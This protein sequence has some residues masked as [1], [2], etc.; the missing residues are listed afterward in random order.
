[1]KAKYGVLVAALLTATAMSAPAFAQNSIAGSV[2]NSASL[3]NSTGIGLGGQGGTA[4]SFSGSNSRS[5]SVSNGTGYGGNGSGTGNATITF[6]DP[7]VPATTTQNIGG[8]ERIVTTG[9]AIAPSLYSN[10]VCA[11]SASAAGGFLG[12][13][14]ALGFDRVDHGCDVRANA[15][16]LGHFAEINRVTAT[17]S[18]DPQ[19][20]YRAEQAAVAYAQWA[21]NYICMANPDLAKAAPPGAG[22]CNQVATQ[23]GMEV[24]PAPV[25]TAYVPPVAPAATVVVPPPR[26]MPQAVAYHQPGT[27]GEHQG[28]PTSYHTGPISGYN[29]PEYSDD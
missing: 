23:Q 18:N 21:N 25:P 19:I 10:N 27:Y 13:A 8:T 26:P 9:A 29:G 20:R 15:S 1:M 16:L 28:V 5:G 6:N 24:V 12:G 7:G 14:F 17:N 3:S 11:L 4:N 2:S 22:F